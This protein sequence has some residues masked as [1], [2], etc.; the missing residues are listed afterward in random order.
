M[1]EAA[2]KLPLKTEKA[3]KETALH[4][5]HPFENL[6]SEI[7]RLF[8]EFSVGW[9]RLPF[10]RQLEPIWRG[11]FELQ[12]AVEVT[13]DDKEYR[14]TAELPGLDEKNVEVSLSDDVLTIKGEKKEETEEK[15][16]D[17]YVSERRF[18]SFQ[19]SFSLPD[20]VD[21]NKIEAS[22][23]KGL[24]T[25]LLPKSAEAQKKSRKVEIKAK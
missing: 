16:K 23:R 3:K 19:R 21:A 24:L 6:R 22:M 9:P 8:D 5:W 17:T 4:P 7:D 1:A 2:T 25:V 18:G 12:P 10:G 13:E 20:G 15:K 11:G 14:V